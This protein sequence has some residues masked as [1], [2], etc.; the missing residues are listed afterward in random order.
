MFLFLFWVL[1]RVR[2]SRL[3]GF[4]KVSSTEP[5]KKTP[6]STRC[7]LKNLVLD[8]ENLY[9]AYGNGFC[10][11]V[12]HPSPVVF[13]S[14]RPVSEL[15][16]AALRIQKFYKSYRTRRNLADCAVVV[17]ELWFVDYTCYVISSLLKR[18]KFNRLRFLMGV[19]I[20][21]TILSQNK[22]KNLIF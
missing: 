3:F 9:R 18:K 2:E 22:L 4:K 14:A 16:A 19:I 5:E 20:S 1:K 13:S 8:Q 21:N 6:L 7:T 17:E 10:E 11:F 12:S 15:N